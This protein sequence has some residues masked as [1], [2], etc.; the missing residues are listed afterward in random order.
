MSRKTGYERRR[1]SQIKYQADTFSSGVTQHRNVE[2][3][4]SDPSVIFV[5]STTNI[6][7]IKR[8]FPSELFHIRLV[9]FSGTWKIYILPIIF[10]TK[11]N[12]MDCISISFLKNMRQPLE[13]LSHTNGGYS[14]I[15]S[16]AQDVS[17]S[18]LGDNIY[19]FYSHPVKQ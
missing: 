9:S 3:P 4:T 18:Y 6:V 11:E 7:L 10:Y 5:S 16:S 17:R 1:P 14:A 8:T 2:R 15:T 13:F 19:A 12:R